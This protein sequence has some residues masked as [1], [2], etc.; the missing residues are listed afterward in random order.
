MTAP[1]PS[2]SAA[3]RAVA[4]GLSRYGKLWGRGHETFPESHRRVLSVTG[5]GA[6]SYLQGLVTCDLN[7]DPP[8]PGQ[9]TEA[10]V[11]AER[12]QLDEPP[13]EVKFSPRMR[14]ACFLDHRGRI[15]SDAMLWKRGDGEGEGLRPR[16]VRPHS[17]P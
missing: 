9:E 13:Q 14:S 2:A 8:R 12:L 4:A 10:E 6:T 7:S 1:P 11:A 17:P 3:A 15:V 16:S 5:T